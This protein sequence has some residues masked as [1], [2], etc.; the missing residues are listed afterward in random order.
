MTVRPTTAPTP[1]PLRLTLG[2]A[3]PDLTQTLTSR[4]QQDRKDEDD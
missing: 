2:S 1:V 4:R 3:I